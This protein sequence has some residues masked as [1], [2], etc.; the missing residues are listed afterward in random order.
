[1]KKLIIILCIYISSNYVFGQGGKGDY[2]E[3]MTQGNYLVLEENYPTALT[4]FLDAYKIDS[5]NSN[6]NYKI[7]LCYLMS[8]SDKKKSLP[9]LEKA[10]QNVSHNY[11]ATDPRE[12]SAPDQAYQLLGD[13]YRL[14][15][16]FN[17]SN[18]YLQKFKDVVGSRNKDIVKD[19]D[20]IMEGNSNAVSFMKD[21]LKVSI[22]NLGD[23][24]NTPYPDYGPIVSSD[25]STLTFTSRR[26][27]STGGDKTD[28]G[29]FFEDIYI[30]QKQKDG[31]WGSAKSI[32]TNVNT[33]GSE[34]ALSLTSD[35]QQL[36]VYRDDGESKDGGDIFYSQLQENGWGY[37]VCM[38][39]NINTKYWETSATLSSDGNILYFVSDRPGGFGKRDIWQSKKLPNGQWS[40]PTNLGPSVNTAYDE[41]APF[42][43]PDGVTLFFSS[44][45]HKNM[46]GFDIFKTTKDSEG[47]WS[48]PENLKY[49]I[50]TTDDDIFYIQ[51]TNG[52][53]GYFSSAR[54]SGFGEKDI[55]MINFE[56]SIAEPLTLLKGSLT[57]DGSTKMPDD[58]KINVSEK[59][60]GELVQS[61][62]PNPRT[63]KFILILNAGKEG[64]DYIITYEASGFEPINETFN[65]PGNSTYQEI[66]KELFLKPINFESKK[67]GTISVKGTIKNNEGKIIPDA[68]I[69]IEDNLTGQ[70]INTILVSSDSGSYYF[71]LNRGQNYNVSYEAPNYLFQSENVNVPKE[72]QFSAITKDIVLEKVKIGAKITL[73][74]I[75]FDSNKSTLRKESNIEIE[76]LF[77]LMNEYKEINIEVDGHTDN[78]GNDV[79]NLALSQARSKAVVDALVKKGIATNRL[80]SKGFGASMPK[81]SNTLANGKPD[82]NGM[83]TNRR[84]ELKIIE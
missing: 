2:R 70:L 24:I 36:F 5:S 83:Q 80:Q 78:K 38:N 32:G 45:G 21:T 48:E 75:F 33:S 63:G 84:V 81:V 1:M 52:K 3:K 16:R 42:L 4:Y 64:K 37:L 19:L 65:V 51:S 25:G 40:L 11:D 7:G 73:N 12:K 27:G 23:S 22:L 61:V 28:D 39:E 57:F 34:A 69:V 10:V 47:K 31:K 71:V 55:Y 66:E 50:N 79:A 41:D 13:A 67:L 30:S 60:S 62:K 44:Q 17:E 46:G 54:K 20:K 29:Q 77:K 26:P 18:T 58:V 74:N 56:Q 35:G 72:P 49:P 68:K 6:I 82:P 43:H 14:D 76:K 9:F 53:V 15:Y 59:I 8:V